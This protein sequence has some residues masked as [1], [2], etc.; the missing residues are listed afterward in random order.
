MIYDMKDNPILRVKNHEY[1]P[2]SIWWSVVHD[3]FI[4]F[5]YAN[6]FIK[7]ILTNLE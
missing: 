2:I 1:I 4:I 3:K 7:I 6:P 5:Y